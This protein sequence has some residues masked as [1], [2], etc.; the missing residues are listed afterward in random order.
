M[1]HIAPSFDY[2]SVQSF[3]RRYLE[4]FYREVNIDE[5]HIAEFLIKQGK[6]IGPN[7]PISL[8]LGCGPTV[9][10]AIAL[11]PYI[12]SLDISDYLEDNINEVKKWV[13][14]SK[15]AF[16]WNHYT[17]E[18]LNAEGLT[19]NYSDIMARENV[20]REKVESFYLCDITKMPPITNNKKYDLVISFYCTEEVAS[21]NAEWEKIMA[22]IS[23]MVAP[24][25]ILILSAIR[26]TDRYILGD[27]KG[28]HEWLP[29]TLVTEKSMRN[30]LNDLGYNMEETEILSIDTPEIV[31][32]GMPGILLVF[33]KKM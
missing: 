33:A 31:E 23:S 20:L 28:I 11:A 8:E 12:E 30:S 32:L 7:K 4:T 18:I 17:E 19:V 10:H 1:T 27:P 9:H 25:G 15:D 26:D 13:D 22:N 21:S 2:K 16:S 29:C 6:K 14:N 3:A 24:G 5:K